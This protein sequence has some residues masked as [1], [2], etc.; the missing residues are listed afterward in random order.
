VVENKPL[1]Q[2]DGSPK[3]TF[4]EFA[5]VLNHRSDELMLAV[6]FSGGGTRAAALAYGVMQELRD[7]RIHLNGQEQSL[8]DAIGIISLVSGG[9]F[10]SAYF[11][12]YGD[13]LFVDFEE[14]FLRRNVEGALL[15][16]VLYTLQ[17]FSSRDRT[18]TAVAYYRQTLFGD[19]TF[20]DLMRPDAP[21]ILINTS[22]L[23]SGARFSFVQDYFNLL[24]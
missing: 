3:Y 10:T 2:S 5:K 19:A 4:S 12:L 11:G 15:R 18:E 23:S 21:L 7:T 9:R 1:S 16:G 20:A 24:C 22:D 8:L 17:W 14:H 6:A 13:R